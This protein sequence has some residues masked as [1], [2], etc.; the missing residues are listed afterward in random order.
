[1]ESENKIH[2]SSLFWLS[3][4]FLISAATLNVL[5][6]EIIQSFFPNRQPIIDTLF[7]L[8]PQIMWTQYLTDLAVLVSPI[9]LL[10]LIIRKDLK[11]LPFYMFVFGFG[12][13][14]RAILI[15]LNPIGGY[16]GNMSNYG[17]TTI[18]QHGM[19][20]SGHTLLVCLAYVLG[21]DLG[22]KTTRLILFSCLILEIVS[23][24]LSRGH[25][26]TDIVGGLL[27]AYF[28]YNEFKKHKKEL[29]I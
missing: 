4:I 27:V 21:R 17:M 23:L 19:F 25:Y 18:M 1:M 26:A 22:N 15:V 12:Y 16:F 8:T 13:A 14:A 2:K 10:I 6:S 9:I 3:V 24:V 7:L 28:V 29:V 20:P 5:G 11:S